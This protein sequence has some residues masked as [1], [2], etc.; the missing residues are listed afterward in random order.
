MKT[1]KYIILLVLTVPIL[2]RSNNDFECSL[3]AEI[4]P[5][6]YHFVSRSVQIIVRLTSNCSLMRD[7]QFNGYFSF[8]R[9]LS[10][11]KHP[12]QIRLSILGN[13]YTLIF[14]DPKMKR[15]ETISRRIEYQVMKIT[16]GSHKKS[17]TLNVGKENRIIFREIKKGTFSIHSFEGLMF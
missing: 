11:R 16:P 12:R 8:N 1:L 6:Q 15:A 3:S 14:S 17:T 13:N 2:S 5:L 9:P 4:H 10:A 7:F